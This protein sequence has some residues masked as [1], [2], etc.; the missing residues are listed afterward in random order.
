M[1][2]VGL[3]FIFRDSTRFSIFALE[4]GLVAVAGFCEGHGVESGIS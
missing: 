3:F 1:Q 2:L 4:L